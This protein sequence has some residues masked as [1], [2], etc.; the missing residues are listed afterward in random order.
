[1]LVGLSRE[2][3][4]LGRTRRDRPRHRRDDAADRGAVVAERSTDRADDGGLP[5]GRLR[6]VPRAL[7]GPG[8]ALS[9]GDD[10]P[11]REAGVVE[12]A[13]LLVADARGRGGALRRGA[14]PREGAGAR[15]GAARRRTR[16]R[17]AQPP[18]G[19][20]PLPLGDRRLAVG[21]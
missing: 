9:L 5:A 2:P 12:R 16:A 21:L 6:A 14:G 17:P 11:A 7:R 4:L 8:D 18:R 1:G 19:R 15:C 13:L 3:G 20:P 10:A